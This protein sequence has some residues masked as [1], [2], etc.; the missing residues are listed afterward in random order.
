MPKRLPLRVVLQ[1]RESNRKF[2]ALLAAKDNS[3]YIHPY[4][5]EGQ[6]WRIP[7]GGAK[8]DAAGKQTLDLINFVEPTLQ[9]HKLTLH[10]SGFIHVTDRHGKRHREGT[11]GPSFR[12]MPLPYDMCTLI[13]CN[14]GLLP[15][16][17]D[18][19]G[20][21]AFIALPDDIGPFYMTITIIEAS[22]P[23]PAVAG[24]LLPKQPINFLFEGLDYGIG[25][26]MWPV[27]HGSDVVP[28]WPSFP[29][30]LVR[31]AA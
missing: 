27:V 28:E 3:F 10:Q 25:L 31:T 22:A 30:F 29:F 12:K 1:F 18:E 2:F 8:P 16:H 17:K 21:A 24:P 13:P 9:M 6:P 26:T 11:R 7:G 5:P 20:H 14:P 15:M 4:R 23:P 19:R